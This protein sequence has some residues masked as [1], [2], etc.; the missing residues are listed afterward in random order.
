[1][2]PVASRLSKEYYINTPINNIPA[3]KTIQKVALEFAAAGKAKQNS[4]KPTQALLAGV[5]Q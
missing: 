3:V 4:D 1:M 5:A 2:F